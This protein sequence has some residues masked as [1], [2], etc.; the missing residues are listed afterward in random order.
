MIKV[1]KIS[2]LL[3]YV[4]SSIFGLLGALCAFIIFDDYKIPLS[5]LTGTIIL[6]IFIYSA[7]I[8]ALKK[9]QSILLEL[10]ENANPKKFLIEAEPLLERRLN[11]TDR[12]TLKVHIANAHMTLGN[13]SEAIKLLTAERLPENAY[14]LRGL[15]LCNIIS[16]LLNEDDT[17]KAKNEIKN[18]EI[19]I[20]NPK[21]PKDFKEKARRTIAFFE[22][23]LKKL[24]ETDVEILKASLSKTKS[25]VYT[26][27]VL[28]LLAKY[29]YDK[30][31]TEGLNTIQEKVEKFENFHK[32]HSIKNLIIG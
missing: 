2:F 28:S 26:I 27:T 32:Y 11:I 23:R 20:S 15:I 19:I 21:C 30:K 29:Y 6:S 10:Y 18:L 1:F 4:F 17:K 31:D 3:A 5:I 9:Y 14:A 8:Y 24:L 12:I 25:S 16:A 22:I 13:N 7:R